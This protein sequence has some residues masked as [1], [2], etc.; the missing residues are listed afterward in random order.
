MKFCMD[1]SLSI[2]NTP[3]VKINNIL[4]H[5]AFVLGKIEGRNMSF[6]VKGRTAVAMVQDA[7]HG[8]VLKKGME[9]IESSS[10]NTGIAL[11]AVG[12]AKDYKVHIVMPETMSVERVKILKTL[13]AE[14]ILTNGFDGMS[15]ALRKAEE[16]VRRQPE[17]FFMPCQFSNPA[18]PAIH[19]RTTGPEL[20]KATSGKIDVLIAGVGTGG[21]IVGIAR[22]IKK[23]CKKNIQVVAVEPA[24]SPLITQKKAG[25]VLTSHSHGIEG[26]GADFIPDILDLSLIDSIE[27]ISSAEAVKFARLLA[28]KEGILAGVSSGAAM[29][30]AVRLSGKAEFRNKLMVAIFPDLSER[31]LR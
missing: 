12:A 18:N 7:E 5:K 27:Q 4:P 9:I 6:S 10:G 28:L 30:A 24:E 26:I 19:R 16:I 23:D 3:L 2:G 29:A 14:V 31:Y 15:G 1:N 22:Y 17:R 13:G 21:T 11:A 8:G 20:W 25:S